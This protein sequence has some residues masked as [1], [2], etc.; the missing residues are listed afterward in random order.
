MI[1]TLIKEC[2]IYYGLTQKEVNQGFVNYKNYDRFHGKG[3][4]ITLMG[5]TNFLKDNKLEHIIPYY[6]KLPITKFIIK[7]EIYFDIQYDMICIKTP[8]MFNF[9]QNEIY[10]I[11][12]EGI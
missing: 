10:K 4:N 6:V 2:C 5:L 9:N 3:V 12:K 7:N 8:F 11:N 1:S